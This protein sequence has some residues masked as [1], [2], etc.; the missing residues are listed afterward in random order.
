MG[1]QALSLADDAGGND[2]PA[3]TWLASA[4]GDWSIDASGLKKSIIGW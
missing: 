4:W 3:E 1:F 2:S